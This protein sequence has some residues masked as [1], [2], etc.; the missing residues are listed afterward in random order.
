M[1]TPPATALKETNFM[2]SKVRIAFAATL[3]ALTAVTAVDSASA[4][5]N[6][7]IY[8]RS[9]FWDFGP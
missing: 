7:Y 1:T 9:L 5:G 4:L 6:K 8:N 3:L 2:L